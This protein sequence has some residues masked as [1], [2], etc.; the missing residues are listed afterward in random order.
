MRKLIMAMAALIASTVCASATLI[1][2]TYSVDSNG[3]QEITNILN[4]PF[5]LDLTVGVAQTFDFVNVFGTSGGVSA[6]SAAF[7]FDLPTIGDPSELLGVDV[8]LAGG[9]LTH[10]AITWAASGLIEVT[11][12]NGAI[13]DITL[14]RTVFNGLS[15][16]YAG[17]TIPITFELIQGPLPVPEPESF[18]LLGVGLLGYAA[19][20]RRRSA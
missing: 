2:G 14:P 17:L 9:T 7:G 15:R 8:Y 16:N 11:F 12:A 18:A 10:D 4:S 1:T 13:L 20:R 3:G 5:S 19:S 6:I